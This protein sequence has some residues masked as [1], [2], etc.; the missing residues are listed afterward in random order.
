MFALA[1]S[2]AIDALNT[3]SKSL[4]AIDGMIFITRDE[5]PGS[6]SRKA[7]AAITAALGAIAI[8]RDRATATATNDTKS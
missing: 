8:P 6:K 4:R 5:L 7:P 2:E 1:S 3:L